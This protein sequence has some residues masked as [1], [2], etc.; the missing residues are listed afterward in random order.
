[1][2]N[3]YFDCVRLSPLMDARRS[4]AFTFFPVVEPCDFV[5]LQTTGDLSADDL[6]MIAVEFPMQ[7]RSQQRANLRDG[8]RRRGFFPP[9]GFPA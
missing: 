5:P 3:S 4:Q 7:R 9:A 2:Q 1:M 6:G 8:D